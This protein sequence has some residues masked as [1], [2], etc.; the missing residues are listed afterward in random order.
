MKKTEAIK[1]ITTAY[2][3]LYYMDDAESLKNEALSLSDYRAAAELMQELRQP[4]SSATTYIKAAA[5]FFKR[6]GYNVTGSAIYK[7]TC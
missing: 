5:D 4:G 7:I 1:A 6:C 3:K 2:S